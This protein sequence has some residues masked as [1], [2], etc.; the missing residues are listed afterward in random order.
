MPYLKPEDKNNFTNSHAVTEYMSGLSAQDFA[1]HVNYLNYL[2]IKK[3]IAKNEGRYWIFALFIGTLICCVLE[4]YRRLVA[5]Y[6]DKAIE[7]N[8]DV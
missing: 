1:G 3:W 5:P 2:A 7:K 6:E 8:G 4:I